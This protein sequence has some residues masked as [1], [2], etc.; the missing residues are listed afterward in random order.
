MTNDGFVSRPIR[1]ADEAATTTMDTDLLLDVFAGH[2]RDHP[3]RTAMRVHRASG[4]ESIG[5]GVYGRMVDEL[6]T[7]L[8]DCGIESGDRVSVLSS[9]RPEWHAA[10]L[11]TMAIGAVTVPLY[12]TAAGPQLAYLLGHSRSRLCFVENQQQLDRLAE[13]L[14][15]LPDLER[16]V[17]IDGAEHAPVASIP[18]NP[19]ARPETWS[20]EQLLRR[21]RAELLAGTN[22]IDGRRALI[23]PSDIAT[24]VYTS[25]T[26][27]PPRGAEITHANLMATVAMIT[28]VLSLGPADR[29]LSFLP[30]SHIAER[31]V[32]HV[33][34]VI[35]G[36]ETWFARSI[37]T[38]AEDL[39]ACRPTIFFAVPRVWE[40]LRDSL[41]TRLRGLPLPLR[42]AIEQNQRVTDRCEAVARTDRAPALTDQVQRALFD[43]TI[44]YSIRRRVGLDRSRLLLSGAAPIDDQLVRWLHEVGITVGQ[45]YGQTEVCG[46]TSMSR[47]GKVRIGTVGA[48]LPGEEVVIAGDGE[49]LVRGP[50]VCRGYFEDDART[51][52]LIDAEHWLHTGDIGTFDREG[53]LRITGRKK[54]LIATS[55]GKKIA[56]Q[57]I[58]NRLRADRFISQAVVIGEGR[59]YLVA[60]ITVDTD[61]LT[62][63]ATSHNKPLSSE[64][65]ASDP[66]VRREIDKAFE[67]VNAEFSS[68]EQVKKWTVLERDFTVEA[69][70]LTPTLKV[71]RPVVSQHY[72]QRIDELYSHA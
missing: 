26:T 7:A 18:T 64:L 60:L 20:F 3:A 11:A 31:I 67:R 33:G 61:A 53:N 41:S 56:P 62:D 36:G 71:V 13:H 63:W 47:P 40:K 59:P 5:W 21:G 66:D 54:D 44:G 51:A 57:E 43:R 2:V 19:K 22:V 72:A 6:A 32:S 23:K 30:L 28:S 27:G 15:D 45:V 35:S 34:Q 10:D 17:L 55:H 4:W 65:L 48:P 16:I 12:P 52:E 58:E 70:E 68:A 8:V 14:A 42:L 9:N 50:N 49:V 25:G 69:G 38:V 46:P 29:F 39:V 37:S 1:S 24:I